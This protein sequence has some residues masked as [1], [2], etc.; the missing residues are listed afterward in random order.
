MSK[1]RLHGSSSGHT[2]VA[3][4]AAAGNNTVTLPNS[5]G[6]LLLTDGSAASLT[7]IPAAN[8][9][10]VCTAGLGNA[11]GAFGQGITMHDVWQVSASLSVSQGDNAI[12]ANWTNG[13]GSGINGAIGSAMTQSSGVFTFPSTGIYLVTIN[14]NYEESANSGHNYAGFYIKRTTDNSSYTTAAFGGNNIAAFSGSTFGFASASYTF[15]VTDVSTHKIRFHTIASGGGMTI[16][17]TTTYNTFWAEFTRLG[18][19]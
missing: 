13:S 14:G 1:I 16:A 12:T 6:T 2:E 5:A 11:S 10:G 18:D 19:T 7:Q 17:G 3:P 4:A 8:I 9:V 15:D